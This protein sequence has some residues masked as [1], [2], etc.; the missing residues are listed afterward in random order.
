M[1]AFLKA[2]GQ[3]VV[4]TVDEAD[5]LLFTGGSDVTPSLYNAEKDPRTQSS[6]SRDV[7]DL[8]FFGTG[9]ARGLALVGICRGAQFLNVMLGGTLHQHV[10]GHRGSHLMYTNSGDSM[11]VTSTHH[12]MLALPSEGEC[13]LIAWGK[14]KTDPLIDIQPEVVHYPRHRALAVQYHPEYMDKHTKGFS[15]F[16]ECLNEYLI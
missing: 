12:Q 3:D 2:G 7:D 1:E 16:F 13:E 6:G 10:E 8:N 15:Y 11:F 4:S 14:E 9:E 5:A